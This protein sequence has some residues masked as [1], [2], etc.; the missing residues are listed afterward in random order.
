MENGRDTSAAIKAHQR[1]IAAMH[2]EKR[3]IFP[4]LKACSEKIGIP[5]SVICKHAKSG[6]IAKG[7]YTFKYL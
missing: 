3:E 4:S 5:S 6:R 7:G 2:G 1:F